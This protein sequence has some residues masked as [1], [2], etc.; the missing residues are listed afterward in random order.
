M[1]KDYPPKVLVKTWIELTDSPY[2]STLGRNQI[3][4]NIELIFGSL[5]V[6]EIYIAN[7]P[8]EHTCYR[9]VYENRSFAI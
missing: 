9:K 2:I 7:M 5:E 3:I 1:A 6:A 4:Q 8:I